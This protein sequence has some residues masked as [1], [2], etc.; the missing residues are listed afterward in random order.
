VIALHALWSRDSQ[1]CVWAEDAS[2]PAR[3][4]KRR[5]RVPEKPRPRAHPFA[6]SVSELSG[7]LDRLGIAP[8]SD[9]Y[10]DS[11]L[12]LV[13]PCARTIEA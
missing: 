7:A 4:P 1:M 11:G 13:L 5:G 12:A 8:A 10:T 2:L 6:G 9:A 3:A